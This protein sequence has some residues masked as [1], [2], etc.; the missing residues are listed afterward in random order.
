[1]IDQ[2]ARFPGALASRKDTNVF[3]NT[4]V[5]LFTSLSANLG[6]ICK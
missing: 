6:Q 2:R 5:V 4:Y 1:M 3:E